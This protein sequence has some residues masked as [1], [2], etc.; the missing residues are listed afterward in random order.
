MTISKAF[1]S[2]EEEVSYNIAITDV[3]CMVVQG[4]SDFFFPLSS[5]VNLQF[6]PQQIATKG[7]STDLGSI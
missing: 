7:F 5:R 6:N 4:K 1:F 3:S 2:G